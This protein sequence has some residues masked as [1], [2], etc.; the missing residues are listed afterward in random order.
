[1]KDRALYKPYISFSN[2]LNHQSIPHV[3]LNAKQGLTI[4]DSLII[5]A[6]FTECHH[7][8]LYEQFDLPQIL[9]SAPLIVFSSIIDTYCCL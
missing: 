5:K 9:F 8:M 3:L 4:Y 6:F 1:M 2:R 7:D